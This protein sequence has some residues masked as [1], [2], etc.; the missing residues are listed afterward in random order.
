MAIKLGHFSDY[1][2]KLG[3]YYKLIIPEKYNKEF[4]YSEFIL[5]LQSVSPQKLKFCED[6]LISIYKN[7]FQMENLQVKVNLYLTLKFRWKLI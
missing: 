1:S 7:L 6:K 3:K 4:T 5:V 2:L